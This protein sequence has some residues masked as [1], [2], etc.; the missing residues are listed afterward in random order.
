MGSQPQPVSVLVVD[1]EPPARQGLARL[2]AAQEGFAVAGECG[3]GASAIEAIRSLAP[4]LVLLDV[5][6]PPPDGLGVVRAVGAE[7]MPAVIFVTA[8]E[9]HAVAAFEAHALDYV[10]KPYTARRL[11][12]ALQRA[13]S[14]IET[15]RLGE[16]GRRLLGVLGEVQSPSTDRIVVKSLGKTE[17]VPVAEISRI[18]A[19]G[20]CVRIHTGRR[21]VVHREPLHALERR[22]PEQRFIR[23][24]RSLLVNTRQ[25]REAR[26]TRSGEHQ[27]VLQDGASVP[28]SRSRWPAVAALLE[29]WRS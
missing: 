18:E 1:D 9:A 13:R 6:M 2:V 22:L 5:Q 4:D 21:V 10:L 20:Y 28:V 23:V 26:V 15:R 7:Q 16:L 25:I 17:L 3:D 29:S 12:E 8:Y 27:L 24:H 19:A 14:Q 11:A